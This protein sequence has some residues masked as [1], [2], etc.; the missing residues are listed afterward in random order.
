MYFFEQGILAIQ[1]TTVS[2]EQIT[3]AIQRAEFFERVTLAV[4]KDDY[5]FQWIIST[6]QTDDYFFQTHSLSL[7]N[8]WIFFQ[9]DNLSIRTDSSSRLNSWK[10]FREDNPVMLIK[11]HPLIVNGWR[12]DFKR[13]VNIFSHSNRYFFMYIFARRVASLTIWKQKKVFGCNQ[14]EKERLLVKNVI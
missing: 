7:S 5:F 4:W 1:S 10:F 13:Q 8:G 11:L 12:I 3:S 14:D 2:F 6:I 9:M